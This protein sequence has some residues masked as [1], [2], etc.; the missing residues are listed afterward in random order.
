[1]YFYTHLGYT[2]GCLLSINSLNISLAMTKR[3]FM[4]KNVMEA[5][6]KIYRDHPETFPKLKFEYDYFWEEASDPPN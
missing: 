3:Q 4:E 6:H 5:V 1:M 2:K